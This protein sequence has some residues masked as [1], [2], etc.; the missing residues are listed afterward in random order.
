M[1]RF[2]I[3]A[4]AFVGAL[5]V[6]FVVG[7]VGLMVLA[8]ASKPSVPSN[9]V[10]ELDLEN[11]LPENSA[12]DSL[13]GAFGE[14]PATVRDVVDALEKAGSDARVK[15]LVVRIGQTGTPAATQE[16]RDAVKAFRA[17]GKKTVAYSDTF[18]ELGNSTLSYYLASAFDEIYIQPSGDLNI[19]GLAFEL[20]FARDAFAKLGVTPQYSARYE[21]KN[22]VN[23]FTEQD[24][25]APHR[26]ATER[27]TQSLFEQMVRGIAEE[28]GLTEDVVRGLID[29]APLMASEALEGKLVTGLRYRDEVMGELKAQAGDG[30]RFLYVEKYLERAGRPHVVGDTIAL[31]YG[32]GEVARGKNRSNPLSG[33]QGMGAE[34]V[35]AALRKATEDSRV[36]AII[37]R[38][39]SPG[40]SYV[41][42]DTIR[43]EVQRAKEAGKPVIATMGGYAASGGYY[44]AMEADRIVAQPGTLTGSIG[45]YAG[46][47]VTA[48]LW[49][50]LGVNFDTVSVGKNA[51]MYGSDAVFTPEQQARLDATLD[52]IYEDFTTRAAAGRKLPLEKLQ[53]LAKGRVWTGEDALA[54]GLVDALG[55][56]PKALELAKEAAKLP[57][58]ARVNVQVYPR[59]KP[60]SAVLSELLGQR[61]ENSE[62]DAVTVS[63]LS[64]WGGLVAGLRQVYAVGAK[65]GLVEGHRGELYAPMPEASW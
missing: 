48:D 43:R 50:K 7:L 38:V 26:E 54:N 20:P 62:D 39:D 55:G 12:G 6:L 64:P 51:E 22:A 25:T 16:I 9:L 34:S 27:F 46:K 4:L 58:D 59:K 37:L 15:A 65:L 49:H 17:K 3:G 1:K 47:F 8:S 60:A 29:K 21:Y 52:R 13:A 10:L 14:E 63:A 53:S 42:S 11:P 56:Y 5:S 57:A 35:A 33:G 2:F 28:R 36:K 32:V 19:T 44:V 40:G 23:S 45:V 41:A 30:A 18:G 24:F 31:V 61:G